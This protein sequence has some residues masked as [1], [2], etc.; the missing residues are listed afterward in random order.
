[1]VDSVSATYYVSDLE[2]AG[3]NLQITLAA[4]VVISTVWLK[5]SQYTFTSYDTACSPAGCTPPYGDLTNCG[6]WCSDATS[7]YRACS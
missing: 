7:C 5:V 4:P 1:M 3:D 6:P 2:N